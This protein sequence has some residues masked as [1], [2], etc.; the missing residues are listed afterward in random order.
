MNSD[1]L[2]ARLRRA[3][4]YEPLGHDGWEA[5][6]RIAALEDDLLDVELARKQAADRAE[7]LRHAK[8]T[9]IAAEERAFALEAEVA[10]LV[11]DLERLKDSETHH[12]NR[13][14]KAEAE[15]AR[16]WGANAN[17]QRLCQHYEARMS[18]RAAL[19]DAKP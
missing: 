1:D 4:E 17:L 18:P 6:D 5:A 11:H 15:V 10:A 3:D 9:Q 13:A 8:M 14:E 16:L 12:L 19:G 7:V 2:I